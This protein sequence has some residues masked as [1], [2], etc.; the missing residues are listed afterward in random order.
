MSRQ[1]SHDGGRAYAEVSRPPKGGR[2]PIGDKAMTATERSRRR[3]AKPRP[4][5][6]SDEI[7]QAL[8]AQRNLF[9]A[10]DRA[11][12]TQI[13]NA[14]VDGDLA[15]AVRALQYLPP[16]IRADVTTPVPSAVEAREKLWQLVLNAKEADEVEEA[17]EV[18]RLRLEVAELRRR[19]GGP[20]PDQAAKAKHVLHSPEGDTKVIDPPTSAI[21]PPSEN[22]HL[23]QNARP[24]PGR[25]DAPKPV[26]PVIDVKPEPVPRPTVPDE[27]DRSANGQAW[28]EWFDREGHL[29]Y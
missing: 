22:S 1:G 4:I 15:E 20:A 6:S 8:V 5:K 10:F 17:S 27:W 18:E 12:A 7:F 23:P 29:F 24:A 11:L 16:V 19:L 14:L 9:S 26:P 21:L 25:Y 13:T 3:R 2:P 28:R